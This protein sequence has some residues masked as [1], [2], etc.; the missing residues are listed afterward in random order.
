M[1]TTTE[2]LDYLRRAHAYRLL[3]LRLCA[4]TRFFAAAA[5]ICE[6]LA[7]LSVSPARL[8]VGGAAW[9]FL[10]ALSTELE[11]V[12]LGIAEHIERRALLR[13]ALD[14]C[15]VRIEQ[16]HVQ[17]ELD[18]LQQQCRADSERLLVDCNRLLNCAHWP[19][20][21]GLRRLRLEPRSPALLRCVLKDL[22]RHR[23]RT[24]DFARQRDREDIGLGLIAR[25]RSELE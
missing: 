14:A 17:R 10:A 15:I 20:L 11:Q 19:G 21:A 13:P 23:A 18:R 25:V 4:R 9:R 2:H 7:H 3:D 5:V 12:N 8:S 16:L 1:P 22:R 24:L 6:A